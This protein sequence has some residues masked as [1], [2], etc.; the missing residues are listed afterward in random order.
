MSTTLAAFQARFV[1]TLFAEEEATGGLAIHRRNVQVALVEALAAAYPVVRRL[2]GEAFF[3]A[4]AARHARETP[5]RSPDLRAFGAGFGDFL[6]T[7]PHAAGLPYLADVA[8]LEWAVHACFHA[9]DA[10]VLAAAQLAQS[11]LDQPERVRLRLHPA[12][13]LVASRHPVQAIHAANQPGCDGTPLRV[14]GPDWL[15]VRRDATQVRIDALAAPEWQFLRRI[16][17]GE[18]L[19]RACEAFGDAAADALGAALARHAGMGL[20]AG[21]DLAPA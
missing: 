8:R 12:V 20:F 2:V 9:E 19:G 14:A 21:F 11:G 1:A 3:E 6:E 10:P 4:A 13:R 7:Y 17:Q 18:P 16:A 5:S 15:L